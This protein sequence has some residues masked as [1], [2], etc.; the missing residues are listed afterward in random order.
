MGKGLLLVHVYIY[1]KINIFFY[2]S[3][4]NVADQDCLPVLRLVQERGNV[5]SYEWKFGTRPD[6]IEENKCI[7][8]TTDENELNAAAQDVVEDV[9]K[10]FHLNC[11]CHNII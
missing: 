9:R 1:S 7:I 6:V 2:F 5:T 10:K 8:D 4:R 3:I 11:S